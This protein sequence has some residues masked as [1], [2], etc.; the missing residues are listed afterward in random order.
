MTF[1]TDPYRI[2][3][4]DTDAAGVV[5]HS[6]YLRYFEAGRIEF[7]RSIGYPYIDFQNQGIGFVPIDIQ[8]K[9]KKPLREDDLYQV[10]AYPT[11]VKKASF[12]FKQAIIVNEEEIVSGTIMLACVKEPEFKPQPTTQPFREALIKAIPPTP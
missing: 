2:Y 5:H 1:L 10:S 9:Y 7:L 6:N 4:Y 11:L 8:I 12:Q 3:V